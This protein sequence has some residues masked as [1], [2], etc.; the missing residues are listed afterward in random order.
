M[1][2]TPRFSVGRC[3]ELLEC[4]PTALRFHR[5]A[6][7]I[8]GPQGLPGW[9]S[10]PD[11][12]PIRQVQVDAQIRRILLRVNGETTPM[13]LVPVQ[14]VLGTLKSLPD[15]WHSR[16]LVIAPTNSSPEG[17]LP[18][19]HANIGVASGTGD[20]LLQVWSLLNPSLN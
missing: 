19:V 16:P 15:S 2:D 9:S 3:L 13:Q 4:V 10:I 12:I 14:K 17:F 5:M 1:I 20:L 11:P 8:T 6:I 7:T 18:I